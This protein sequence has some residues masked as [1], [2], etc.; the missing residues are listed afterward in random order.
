MSVGTSKKR[1]QADFYIGYTLCQ[2]DLKVHCEYVDH[3]LE[4]PS[5]CYSSNE[6]E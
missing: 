3:I 1:Y 2:A 6:I 5:A 4:T